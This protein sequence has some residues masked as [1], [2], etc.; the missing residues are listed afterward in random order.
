MVCAIAVGRKGA[1]E[2][3]RREG[4]DIGTHIKAANIAQD[5]IE[6]GH[7]VG[8]LGQEARLGVVLIVVIVKAAD[9]DKE[10]LSL[11]AQR[12]PRRNHLG[13]GLELQGERALSD[14]ARR[15]VHIG[16]RRR[17]GGR[18]RP[19][20]GRIETGGGTDRA[21]GQII[22][23]R[24]HQV[25]VG[26]TLDNVAHNGWGKARPEHRSRIGSRDRD[27][28]RVSR[29]DLILGDRLPRQKDCVT[30]QGHAGKDRIVAIHAGQQVGKATAPPHLGTFGLSRLPGR[31]LVIVREQ[32][33]R[34]R[35]RL[36]LIGRL[37]YR[38]HQRAD[39]GHRRQPARIK[40]GS[41]GAQCRVKGKRPCRGHGARRYRIDRI[42]HDG[43]HPAPSLRHVHGH[44]ALG[45]GRDLSHRRGWG[46]HRHQGNR[47]IANVAGVVIAG[48]RVRIG[49]QQ[50]I[51]GVIAAEHEQADQSLIV[52][53][54]LSSR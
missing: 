21:R 23:V 11:Q 30:G 5:T 14:H 51:V 2:V 29:R 36:G 8:D 20:E 31:D 17:N 52:R 40:Q 39:I 27:C 46:A 24:A 45:K 15:G 42:G 47:L 7:G 9:A 10:H 38:G 35:R 16:R 19:L 12:R 4:G 26:G 13:D 48:P 6:I 49:G 1:R 22:I 43:Q 18:A 3:R 50:H 37:G 53:R 32:I 34:E 33:E 54:A 41:Q 25:G 44:G 28:G